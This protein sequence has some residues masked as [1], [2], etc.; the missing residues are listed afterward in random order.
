MWRREEEEKRTRR[1]REKEEK[2]TRKGLESLGN[3][4]IDNGLD[5]ESSVVCGTDTM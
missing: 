4:P 1:G 3:D 5:R 2:R